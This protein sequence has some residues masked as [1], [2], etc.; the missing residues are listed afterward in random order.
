[1]ELTI[2]GSN[3]AFY[4]NLWNTSD[5]FLD[6]SNVGTFAD[7]GFKVSGETLSLVPEP[8]AYGLL[9]GIL[10]LGWVMVRRR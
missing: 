3:F 2:T 9:A 1:M 4:E 6:G 7:S 5:L 8:S 10:A